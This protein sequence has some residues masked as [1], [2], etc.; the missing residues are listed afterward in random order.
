MRKRY[1]DFID[2]PHNEEEKAEFDE[3]YEK[4]NDMF[5]TD[6][7]FIGVISRK[8]YGKNKKKRAR[9]GDYMMDRTLLDLYKETKQL[10]RF[11]YLK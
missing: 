9:F 6:V 10:P 8:I 3:I 1:K 5:K 7:I 2:T 4:Y 11:E